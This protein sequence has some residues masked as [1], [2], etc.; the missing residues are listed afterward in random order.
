M[1]AVVVVG[2]RASNNTRHLVEA[3]QAIGKPVQWVEQASDLD[4]APLR[5]LNVVGL[6]A[7]ASTPTWTVDEV[8]EILE[9][10]G[11]PS[12]L[13]RAGR[14]S[15]TLQLPVALGTGLLALLLHGQLEWPT[16]WSGP[17]LPVLFQLALCAILP[18]LDPLGIDAQGWLHGQFLA[19]HRS[20]FL[21]FLLAAP[22][23][24]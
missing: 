9:R 12:R 18:Y 24:G 2:G 11:H 4:L 21:A 17:A 13:R 5:G 10:A 15:R 3:V 1:D 19:K 20:A 14:I 23:L 22:H 7:G 8:V 16:G 6:L